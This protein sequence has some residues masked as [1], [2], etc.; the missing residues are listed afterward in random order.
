MISSS[1]I[2]VALL[3]RLRNNTGGLRKGTTMHTSENTIF[4]GILI[5]VSVILSGCQNF[6]MNDVPG[7]N[8]L[9][10]G[11]VAS[12]GLITDEA[13]LRAAAQNDAISPE[14]R[15]GAAIALSDAY[16]AD[17][18]SSVSAAERGLNTGLSV[19]GTFAHMGGLL[20]DGTGAKAAW[21]AYG[22]AADGIAGNVKT[23]I[24]KENESTVL[25]AAI[26]KHRSEQYSLLLSKLDEDGPLAGKPFALM[27][28]EIQKYH[29]SCTISNAIIEVQASVGAQQEISTPAPVANQPQPILIE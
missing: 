4:K 20:A 29:S 18:F 10:G 19:F 21:N 22:I 28:P 15:L 8:V 24:F 6:S 14:E 27:L 12:L 9:P 26:R 2:K 1:I 11:S 13:A 7:R 23:D 25:M 17:Y 16:C 5:F 3:F